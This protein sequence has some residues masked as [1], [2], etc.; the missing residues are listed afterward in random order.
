MSV[1]LEVI[2]RGSTVW[3]TTSITETDG[4][5]LLDVDTNEIEFY[6][7]NGILIDTETSPTHTSTGVYTQAYTIPAGSVPGLWKVRWIAT[8]GFY[9]S[10]EDA[11]F[12]VVP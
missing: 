1:S 2:I 9:P 4:T 10:I 12:T 11:E 7:P 8:Q 3:V 6:N 5:T